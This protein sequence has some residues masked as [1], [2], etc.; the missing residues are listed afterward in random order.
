MSLETLVFIAELIG[1]AAFAV[2]GVAVA[3]EKEL[4]L[5]GA[6][7]LGCLTACGGGLLRDLLIGQ[8]PPA[9][10][11]RPI[12]I[13]VAAAVSLASFLVIRFAGPHIRRRRAF[14]A[15]LVNIADALGLAVFV[16]VGIDA[17][18]K[19]GFGANAFL[20]VSV[21]V[22]TGVGGGLTRDLLAGKI[23][24]ILY[25]RVYAVAAIL[26]GLAYMFLPALL[27]AWA[28]LLISVALVVGIRML[29]TRFKWSLPH[30]KKEE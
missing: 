26:G 19:M 14:Y 28:A 11:V 4:D 13:A 12:P 24:G 8:I 17:A 20:C 21:G 7:L 22:L 9:L 27:P 15:G 29:A 5:F 23:P 16:V 1:T 25:K 30:L 2:T 10:F 18:R 3:A 6:I